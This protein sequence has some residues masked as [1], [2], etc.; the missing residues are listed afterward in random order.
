MGGTEERVRRMA[1][2]SNLG[3]AKQVGVSGLGQ[4]V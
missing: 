4:P 2:P 3:V 1:L